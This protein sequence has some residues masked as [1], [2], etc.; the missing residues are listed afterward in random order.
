MVF[1]SYESD[2]ERLQQIRKELDDMASEGFEEDVRHLRTMLKDPAKLHDLEQGLIVLMKKAK[3]T[4][5]IR[6]PVEDRQSLMD[7]I[8]AL[9]LGIPSVLWGTSQTQ[10]VEDVLTTERGLGSD[11]VPVVRLKGK[12]FNADATS[13]NFLTLYKGT[14]RCKKEVAATRRKARKGSELDELEKLLK[15]DD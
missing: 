2:L 3:E 9:P 10:L 4:G 15:E 11:D 8:K 7:A 13:K 14:V 12:W 5:T 1:S 6:L